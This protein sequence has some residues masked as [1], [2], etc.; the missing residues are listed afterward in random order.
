MQRILE[1]EVMDDAK[2]AVAYAEADFSDSNEQFVSDVLSEFGRDLINV[3][4]LGCGPADIPVRLA[5][6]AATTKLKAVD[7]SAEML[8]LARE[9]VQAA[10]F[11]DRIELLQARLPDLPLPDH[12][13]ELILS[14]DMLHHLPDPDVL[15]REVERLGKPGAGVFVM[16]LVRPDSPEQAAEIVERVA[17]DE[18]PLLKEDFY[19][20]LCAAFT[21]SEVQQQLREASIPL[22]VEQ[23]SDRHMRIAGYLDT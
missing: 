10:G 12:S 1:T 14:K 20:S 6:S 16:D 23:V 13:F 9:A 3:I 18:H 17:G 7:A 8:R 11:S 2:E 22:K 4:D 5:K 21:V 15:W 19:N